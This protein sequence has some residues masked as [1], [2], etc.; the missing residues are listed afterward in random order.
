MRVFNQCVM[1]IAIAFLHAPSASAE[2]LWE[3]HIC[4]VDCRLKL[5]F[6]DYG[7]SDMNALRHLEIKTGR[8]GKFDQ[9]GFSFVPDEDPFRATFSGTIR[10]IVDGWSAET[11][12]LRLVRKT[13]YSQLWKIHTDDAKRSVESSNRLT[14][15]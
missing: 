7:S 15:K 12:K 9:A 6:A 3:G 1:A 13:R 8:A 5:D 11:R 2:R 4:F 10:V 14:E